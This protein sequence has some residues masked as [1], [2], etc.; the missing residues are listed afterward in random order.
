M[1][2]SINEWFED[3]GARGS[4]SIDDERVE[5]QAGHLGASPAFPLATGRA[6]KRRDKDLNRRPP[7]VDGVP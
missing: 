4:N 6:R 5:Y 2:R 7:G 1:A 3:R